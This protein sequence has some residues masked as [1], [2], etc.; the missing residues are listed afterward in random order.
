M[1]LTGLFVEGLSELVDWRRNLKPLLEY[2]S[3]SLDTNVLRPFDESA[4]IAVRL[5][6]LADTEVTRTLLEEGVGLLLRLDLL[7]RQRSCRYLL[8]Y[9][10][11]RL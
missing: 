4:E 2:S 8:S 3:L 9:L 10:L 1:K 11:L 5:D 6:V 7:H